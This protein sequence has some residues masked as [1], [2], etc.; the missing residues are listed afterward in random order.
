MCDLDRTPDQRDDP[1][2]QAF[3]EENSIEKASGDGYGLLFLWINNVQ[4]NIIKFSRRCLFLALQ[5]WSNK[6]S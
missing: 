6:K 2:G 4:K 5:M 3:L 1:R